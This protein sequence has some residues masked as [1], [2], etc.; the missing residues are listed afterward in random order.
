ME[1]EE[2]WIGWRRGRRKVGERRGADEDRETVVG[3]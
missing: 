1:M 2:E 3:L